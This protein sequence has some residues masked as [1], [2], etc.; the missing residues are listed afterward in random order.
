MD[1]PDKIK[2]K[3]LRVREKKN[4]A[5]NSKLISSMIGYPDESF[6]IR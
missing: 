4:S 1:W 2:Q 3:I 5:I 6:T